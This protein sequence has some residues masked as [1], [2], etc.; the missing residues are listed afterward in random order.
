M[1]K[2][3]IKQVDAEAKKMLAPENQLKH[4]FRIAKLFKQIGIKKENKRIGDVIDNS[5]FEFTGKWTGDEK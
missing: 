4:I 1:T 2:E 3:E 5:V